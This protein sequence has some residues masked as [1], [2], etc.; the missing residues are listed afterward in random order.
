MTISMGAIN[1]L[2]MVCRF[3]PMA[4]T[5]VLILNVSL[6]IAEK[7]KEFGPILQGGAPKTPKL[8]YNSNHEDLWILW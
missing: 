1:H 4:V 7:P 6:N 3:Q 8:V 5:L 2:H